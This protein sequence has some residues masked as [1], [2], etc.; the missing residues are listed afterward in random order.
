MM[1]GVTSLSLSYCWLMLFL[2]AFL[3]KV[4]VQK[5]SYDQDKCKTV[6]G[7]I[8]GFA[9]LPQKFLPSK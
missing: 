1:A 3:A 4:C 2:L 9:D 7:E 5:H 8:T 6:V